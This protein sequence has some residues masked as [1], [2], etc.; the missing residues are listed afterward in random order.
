MMQFCRLPTSL[1]GLK[2]D[3]DW[4]CKL[5][6]KELFRYACAGKFAHNWYLCLS[7][8]YKHFGND[9]PKAWRFLPRTVSGIWGAIQNSFDRFHRVLN[10]VDTWLTNPK[11][12]NYFRIMG[13][14]VMWNWAISYRKS[15]YTRTPDAIWHV[16]ENA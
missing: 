1:H 8:I 14:L 13:L 12:T 5:L 9:L 4:T 7:I 11:F 16:C 2:N 15:R 10:C 6:V 3:T